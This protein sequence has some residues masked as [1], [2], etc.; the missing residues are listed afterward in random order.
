MTGQ[1]VESE[2]KLAE[3]PTS[4]ADSV[5]PRKDSRSRLKQT[6]TQLHLIP[7]SSEKPAR[8]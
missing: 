1:D 4:G 6:Q 3:V 2:G 8:M 5:D 7:G